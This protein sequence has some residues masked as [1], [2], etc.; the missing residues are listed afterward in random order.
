MINDLPTVY[1]VVAG[2]AKYPKDQVEIQHNGSKSKSSG[3]IIRPF[4]VCAL[5]PLIGVSRA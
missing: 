2:A 1:E 5:I 4:K 3:K